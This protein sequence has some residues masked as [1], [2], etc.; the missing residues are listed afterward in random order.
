MSHG[1]EQAQNEVELMQQTRTM[2]RELNAFLMLKDERQ[3]L[4]DSGEVARIRLDLVLLA[5]D[6]VA[7]AMSDERITTIASEAHRLIGILTNDLDQ[8]SFG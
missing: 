5:D 3:Q 4:I 7:T 8:E 1:C 2:R 6:R